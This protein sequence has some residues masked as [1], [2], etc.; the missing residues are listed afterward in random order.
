MEV[1]VSL[2]GRGFD[3]VAKRLGIGYSERG[4]VAKGVVERGEDWVIGEEK[5]S[6]PPGPKG[7]AALGDWTGE[8]YLSSLWVRDRLAYR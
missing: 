1:L 4:K 8:T 3:A 6:V 5:S 2:R 7:R